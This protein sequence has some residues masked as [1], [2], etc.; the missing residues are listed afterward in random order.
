MHLG[1]SG[2]FGVLDPVLLKYL[3]VT[4]GLRAKGVRGLGRHEHPIFWELDSQP[5]RGRESVDRKKLKIPGHLGSQ[6]PGPGGTVRGLF[7][8]SR[9]VSRALKCW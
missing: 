9:P 5:L 8:N 4:Q 1:V 2:T 6:N 3:G 7:E